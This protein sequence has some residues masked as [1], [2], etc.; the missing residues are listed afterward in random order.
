MRTSLVALGFLVFG[1][2]QCGGERGLFV[3]DERPDAGEGG[4]PNENGGTA[5]GGNASGGENRGGEP[6]GGSENRG[7][8]GSGAEAGEPGTAATGGSEPAGGSE[9]R[10]GGGTGAEAGE[11]GTGG[12]AARGGSE[13]GGSAGEGGTAARGGMAGSGAEAGS[14]TAARGGTGD[15][16]RAGS[17]NAGAGG[18]GGVDCNA[19]AREYIERLAL[20][21]QCSTI[22]T[23][24]QCTI[25]MPDEFQCPCPTYVNPAREGD[26]RRLNQILE[27][28]RHCM[29]ACPAI[30]CPDPK[31]GTCSAD[32]IVAGN[33][34]CTAVL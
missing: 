15:G 9:N 12:V 11:A 34:R 28:A 23:V 7:G 18:S 31:R 19:L 16:G 20:A 29:W 2:A 21:Q 3:G 32:A 10:G 27:Y 1:L 17:S 25:E 14:G 26:I 24:E 6:A 4:E 33:G 30:V 8:S 5:N 13:G 22:L